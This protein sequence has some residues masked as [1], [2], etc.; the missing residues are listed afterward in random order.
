[1]SMKSFDKFCENI[2]L[3]KSGSDKEIYD[4]RQK[5][6]RMHLTVESLA[7]YVVLSALTLVIHDEFVRLCESS[8]FILALCGSAAYLWWVIRCAYKECLFGVSGKKVIYTATFLIFY[9]PTILIIELLPN[10][11]EEFTLMTESGMSDELSLIICGVL[12]F[13]S[14]I[15]TFAAYKKYR[16][17]QSDDI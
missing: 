1:M 16:R 13:A 8:F 5:I 12:F 17:K 14:S 3:G 7:V 15:I 10:M 11:D 2:I 6:A 4:E 9:L